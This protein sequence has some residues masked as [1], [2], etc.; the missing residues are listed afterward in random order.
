[1]QRE[2]RQPLLVPGVTVGVDCLLTDILEKYLPNH[3]FV[4]LWG[5]GGIGKTTIAKLIFNKLQI[6][7]PRFEFT[8][9]VEDMKQYCGQKDEVK[10][11]VW[12]KMHRYGVPVCSRN[13]SFGYEWN[14]VIGKSLLV[15]FDGVEHRVHAELLKEIA[16]LNDMN[17]SRFILTGRNAQCLEGCGDGLQILPLGRLGDQDAKR[18]LTMY[19]FPREKEPPERF[20]NVVEQVV[21][22]CDGLPLT[23]EILGKYL[24]NEGVDLWAEIPESL[25]NCHKITADL[26]ERVWAKVKLSY[27][28]LPDDEVKHMFLDIASFFIYRDIPF[29]PEEAV[30][31]WHS[32]YRSGRN[33]LRSLIDRSLVRLSHTDGTVDWCN[34]PVVD[35]D[36]IDQS[37]FYMHEHVRRMGEKIARA[38][39][40]SCDFSRIRWPVSLPLERNRTAVHH[41]SYPCNFHAVFE[42]GLQLGKVVAHGMKISENSASA[43]TC[44]LCI[45][46]NVLPKFT[47]VQYMDL[48]VS[49]SGCCERCRS[50]D[51]LLALPNTLVLL[52]LSGHTGNL[53]LPREAGGKLVA[54]RCQRVDDI[55]RILSANTYT[56][57][58]KLKLSWCKNVDQLSDSLE[59]LTELQILD[60]QGSSYPVGSLPRKLWQLKC[61]ERLVLKGVKEVFELPISIGHLDKLKYLRISKCRL[62]SLPRTFSWLKSLQF[63]EVTKIEGDQSISNVIGDFRQLRILKMDCW[64]MDDLGEAFKKLV[65][66][67]SLDLVC[68]G[69]SVLSHTVGKLT[70]LKEL[71]LTAPLRFL[72]NA[73]GDLTRLEDVVLDC[74][75]E[76]FPE[77]FSNLTRLK[78][79]RLE[80][81][82]PGAVAGAV[83]GLTSLES[84]DVTVEGP[85]AVQDTFAE[86]KKLRTFKLRC[87][88]VTNNLVETFRGL[89]SLED[90]YLSCEVGVLPLDMGFFSTLRTL[91]IHGTSL[92]S[93]P[94]TFGKFTR[95]QTLYMDYTGLHSLPDS[96][97]QLSQLQDLRISQCEYLAN[98]PD[99]LGDLPR[100]RSLELSSCE[101]LHCLPET[102]WRLSNL[103]SL[104][105]NRLNSLRSIPKG[106][107]TLRSLQDL[108][109]DN[110]AVENL[111]ESLGQLSSL[112][113]LGLLWCDNLETLPETIGGLSS[114]VSLSVKGSSLRSLP[115]AVGYMLNLKS[116]DIRFCN[117]L[118]VPIDV[119]ENIPHLQILQD[120]RVIT[121]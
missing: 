38:C 83:T 75:I 36:D 13:E 3:A 4:G 29:E 44:R 16:D 22:V 11:Q 34:R 86:L 97:G 70:S 68:R 28:G 54:L 63:L 64:A 2:R 98:V 25:R 26:D 82:Q 58:T 51:E 17:N 73:F 109:I 78:T 91:E 77:R 65:A 49:F 24:R 89:G 60:I 46:R 90:L 69:M 33:R 84:L 93:L 30:M 113:S 56:S 35:W 79:L 1:M 19:S 71:K 72:P 15:I 66:V 76:S 110:C 118:T 107:E 108:I 94:A 21:E 37:V 39:G 74:P 31:A 47:E 103:Q 53:E 111:P 114:L 48:D 100:L 101:S 43:E 80:N 9:F 87:G 55:R 119:S 59:R 32:M 95:L 102:I 88:A 120:E 105:L 116:L 62:R 14:Q 23:L 81:C 41:N 50:Q 7:N 52:S 40:R 8:C 6:S 106:L 57:L 42:E 92:Q 18:L 45:M 99:T 112:T 61:L 10:R 96:L 12:K 27:D 104:S 67:E 121:G 85:G 115:D 117:D 5:V 20:Q